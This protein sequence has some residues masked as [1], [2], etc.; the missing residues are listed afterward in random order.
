[1]KKIKLLFILMMMFWLLGSAGPMYD[2]M[3]IKPP[4]NSAVY[5]YMPVETTREL[6]PPRRKVPKQYQA[7]FAN[8]SESAGLPPGVLESIAYVESRFTAA[9]RSPLYRNGYSDC[10][11]FQFNSRFLR[12]YSDTYNKGILFDPFNP[13]EAIKI[14]ALHISFLHKRYGNWAEAFMAYNAGMDRI[15]R[16]VIPDSAWDYLARIYR[17][18]EL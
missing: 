9:I 4:V 15:D 16:G 6:D 8:A 3:L 5:H 14:A 17:S 18:D 11:M 1:M 10:G 13:D 2:Y 7:M 12:W